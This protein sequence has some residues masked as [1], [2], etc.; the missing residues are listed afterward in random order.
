M[1]RAQSALSLKSI[2]QSINKSIQQHTKH[3][4]V[5][6]FAQSKQEVRP[7]ITL[8]LAKYVSIPMNQKASNI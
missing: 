6:K 2:A 8:P 1:K 3:K 5:P 4:K 7:T